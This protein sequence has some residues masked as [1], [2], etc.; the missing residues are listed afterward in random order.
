MPDPQLAPT[1]MAATEHDL[2]VELRTHLADR[3]VEAVEWKVRALAAERE[4]A[5]LRLE[6]N[7]EATAAEVAEG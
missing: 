1:G 7:T 4:L 2:I 6:A 3:Y 5:R